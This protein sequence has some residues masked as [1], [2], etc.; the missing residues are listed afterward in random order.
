MVKEIPLTQ[1]QIALVDDEDY[2][3]VSAHGW[4]L[5]VSRDYQRAVSRIN[6]ILVSMADFILK[7]DS[8][9]EIDHV[10]H[11]TLDNRRSNIRPCT[12]SQNLMNARKRTGNCTSQF[13]GVWRDKTAQ[14][15]HAE[16][17]V[18]G[19][20]IR[21]GTSSNER[22]AAGMYNHAA[23]QHFGKFA[24]VN[25]VPDIDPESVRQRRQ[26]GHTSK[27]RG[28]SFAKNVS[29]WRARICHNGHYI[30]I[31]Y[32]DTEIKATE[33]VANYPRINCSQDDATM[34]HE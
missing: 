15:W 28:V 18:S 8:R 19:E 4:C 33:A 31:G 9:Q 2:E 14:T 12:R 7:V 26:D 16:I 27:Y 23:K 5:H 13:K 30:H 11:D 25:S 21:I 1:G 20:T 22:E 29:K 34:I 24:Y 6:S 10:N 17:T 3:R 32:F